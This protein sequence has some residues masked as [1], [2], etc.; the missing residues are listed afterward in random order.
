[1]DFEAL[2]RELHAQRA[3]HRLVQANAED[4]GEFK[5][6]ARSA[7]SGDAAA[8][9]VLETVKALRSIANPDNFEQHVLIAARVTRLFKEHGWDLV[10][11]GGS[12]L[13]FYTEG[14]YVSGDIDFCRM[15]AK[16]IPAAV[17]KEVMEKVGAISTGTRRQWTVGP[18]FVELLGEI[19]TSREPK[20]RTLETPEG[21]V[22]LEPA[23]DILV[24]RVWAAVGIKSPQKEA[25]EA[26]RKM[27]LVS[28]QGGVDWEKVRKI[29]GSRDY[30]ILPQ[31][32]SFVEDVRKA[33][34]E[35]KVDVGGMGR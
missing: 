12:A 6:V 31:L 25:V 8:A 13:E 2:A 30:G 16:P 35:N 34:D 29:A 27:V 5:E 7:Q 32:T 15:N 4:S 21:L 1:V 22:T 10:V 20:Y 28:L 19:E 23:E 17:E 26:A 14:K 18:V 33:K 3:G 11:V 9:Q 24:D